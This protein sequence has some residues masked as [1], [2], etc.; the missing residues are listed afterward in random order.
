[1][2][3]NIS[4]VIQ[5]LCVQFCTLFVLVFTCRCGVSKMLF[6]CE[7]KGFVVHYY[8]FSDGNLLSIPE[9][10]KILEEMMQ[11]LKAGNRICLQSPNG[12][13]KSCMSE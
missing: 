7:D 9:T 1:M 3:S 12:I 8:P 13:G 5:L 2:C 6:Q 11:C 10:V 4:G